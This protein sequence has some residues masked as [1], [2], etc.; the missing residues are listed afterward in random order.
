VNTPKQA[1]EKGSKHTTNEEAEDK[2]KQGI[3]EGEE[4]GHTLDATH[5]P[6]KR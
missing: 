4:K 3:K 2:R 6:R 1:E 5:P